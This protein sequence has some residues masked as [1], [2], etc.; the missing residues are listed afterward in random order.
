[1]KQDEAKRLIIQEWDRWIQTQSFDSAGA[2]GRDSLR[3]FLELEDTRSA[4][5]D[6]QTR[7]QDKWQVVHSWLLGARRLA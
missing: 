3:F 6:F 5:L 2:T 1:M 7:G 4:L